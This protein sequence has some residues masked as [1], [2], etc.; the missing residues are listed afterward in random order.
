[1]CACNKMTVR[2]YVSWIGLTFCDFAVSSCHEI[3][4]FSSGM[5]ECSETKRHCVASV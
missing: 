5:H 2:L 1:M 3:H 4:V